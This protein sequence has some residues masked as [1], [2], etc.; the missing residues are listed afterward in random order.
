[1][2]VVL[3]DIA[4]HG[5]VGDGVLRATRGA[6]RGRPARAASCG[7]ATSS[8]EPDDG[9]LGWILP[10]TDGAGG[11]EAVDPVARPRSRDIGGVTLTAGVCDLASCG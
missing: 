11:I 1:M 9:E 10:E 5:R 3:A 7:R 4:V 6:P 8:R 2:T